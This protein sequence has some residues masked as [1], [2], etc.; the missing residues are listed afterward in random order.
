[1]SVE[2]HVVLPSESDRMPAGKLVELA[3]LA[4]L[5]SYM[6]RQIVKRRP[7]RATSALPFGLYL[8]PSIWLGWL[9]QWTLLAP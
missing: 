5:A 1:M 9:L 3:V 2:L 4:A 6:L 8:A 7:L